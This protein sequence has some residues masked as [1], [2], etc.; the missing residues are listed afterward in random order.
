MPKQL[1][2][3][4]LVPA[5][6]S[7]GIISAED[8]DT[9]RLSEL[10]AAKQKAAASTYRLAYR[11]SPGETFR[12][13]VVH[14]VTVDTKIRGVS[15]TAQT[16]S[17]STKAWKITEVDAKGNTTF[18]Y[19]V[20]S[21]NMWQKLTGRQEIRYDS[22]EDDEPPSEYKHVA[23]SIGTPMATVTM[24]PSGQITSRTNARPQFNPGI[25]ELTIPLP[26][27]A[28]R[29]GQQWSIPGELA[30]RVPDGRIKRVK[31]RQVYELE[32]VKTGVATISVK[33]QVLTPVNDP[34]LQSQLVQRVK[35]GRVK[36]DVDA[37]RPISQQMDVDE[38]VIGFSGADSIMKYLSR[39]TEEV[40]SADSI[41]SN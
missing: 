25:G 13:K 37:G 30:L 28:I 36:F 29:V 39:L 17:V 6:F 11:F 24:T 10:E 40:V 7:A 22:T 4:V 32:A 14:L 8:S 12:L 3:F 33:T 26:E 5:L 20:E 41:A 1:A 15:E 31:T 19:T 21:V 9:D 18:T 2:F 34:V 27:N 35:S 23:A 16:R 38:T